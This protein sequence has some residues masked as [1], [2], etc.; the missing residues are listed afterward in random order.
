MSAPQDLKSASPAEQSN[1][2]NFMVLYMCVTSFIVMYC[3]FYSLYQALGASFLVR[4]A[5]VRDPAVVPGVHV[6]P[7]GR[8]AAASFATSVFFSLVIGLL[9]LAMRA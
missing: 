2:K 7:N 1:A 5:V 8:Y 4:D 9:A 3:L 6:D